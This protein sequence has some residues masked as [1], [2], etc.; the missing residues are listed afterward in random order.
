MADQAI[1]ES[2]DLSEAA[3]VDDGNW[4]IQ[5]TF[6]W[7]DDMLEELDRDL[8]KVSPLKFLNSLFGG[9]S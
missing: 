3:D 1:L 9:R 4:E 7:I 8:A 5:A 2:V 6:G